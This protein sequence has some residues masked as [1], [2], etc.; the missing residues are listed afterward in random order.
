M[1][2]KLITL[3]V[4]S[5]LFNAFLSLFGLWAIIMEKDDYNYSTINFYKEV[6][7]KDVSSEINVEIHHG[8]FKNEVKFMDGNQLVMNIENYNIDVFIL[9]IISILNIAGLI[10]SILLDKKISK[11]LQHGI[12]EL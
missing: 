7:E 10:F 11:N 3:I 5:V 4:L 1:K 9:L 12:S 2:K 8:A 6:I